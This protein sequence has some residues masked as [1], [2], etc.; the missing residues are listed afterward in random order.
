MRLS[1][2]VDAMHGADAVICTL[3]TMPEGKDDSARRQPGVP[4]CSVGTKNILAA[5]PGQLEGLGHRWSV[6]EFEGG[7]SAAGQP[8][9]TELAAQQ[10]APQARTLAEDRGI[11]CVV[12]DY[13]E[14]RGIDN[15]EDR[16]F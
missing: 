16:L 13:D 10:I 1:S 14:L 7:I 2:V 5:L 6:G 11:R 4:V 3:G 8:Q 12:F 15:K 9:K